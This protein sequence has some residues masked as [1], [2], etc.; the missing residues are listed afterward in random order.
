MQKIILA[1]VSI[2]LFTNTSFGQKSD[3]EIFEA[4]KG[5]WEMPIKRYSE[6]FDNEIMKHSTAYQFDSII[7]IFTD[8]AYSIKAK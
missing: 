1:V 5:K 3:N 4:S 2:L 6:I 8:S 7:R